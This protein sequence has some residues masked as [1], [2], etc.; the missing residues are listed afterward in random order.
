MFANQEIRN[1]HSLQAMDRQA[2][3]QGV[4][5]REDL[6][7]IVFEGQ[8]NYAAFF[9]TFACNLRC[10][11]CINRHGHGRSAGEGYGHLSG[12]EWVR[13]ANRLVLRD[14]LPL[15]LQGGEPT[16]HRDF[17]QLVNEVKRE[18]K[19]DLLTN[20]S[21]DVEKF[22]ANVPRWRFIREAP[23]APIRVSYHPGQNDIDELKR[24]AGRLMDAGFR[25]GIYGIAH[26]DKEIAAQIE[27]VK[28]QC[29]NEG[30]DF[31]TKEF[32][33]DWQGV[34]YGTY[35]YDGAVNG[36]LQEC[37]C[38][39]T[40]LIVAPD[41]GVYRCHADL[42]EHR[43]PVGH[44]FDEHFSMAELDTFRPCS[45]FGTCNPCDVKVKTNRF[46]QFGHTSCEVKFD[47]PGRRDAVR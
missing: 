34:L 39:T 12:E 7:A 41:G 13:A 36:G 9:L 40:E 5:A 29:L 4:G 14:D 33:G 44:I 37:Y 3:L 27:T 2:C 45:L 15:T 21:F 6:P 16:L 32:L 26:P 46:Q 43:E 28:Q 8:H 24:K 25:I 10:A 38:K 18:I 11:Y 30:L 31:R 1:M 42:Y 20:L 35:K 47:E 19:M 23:Y 22:I 17:Y